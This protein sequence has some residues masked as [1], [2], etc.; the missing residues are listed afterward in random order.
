[1]NELRLLTLVSSIFS[2]SNEIIYLNIQA[3]SFSSIQYFD[4]LVPKNQEYFKKVFQIN[5]NKEMHI[6]VI[7]KSNTTKNESVPCDF[8]SIK[9][10]DEVVY[11]SDEK[12]MPA[13]LSSS[14]EK[15]QKGNFFRNYL[16]KNLN[17]K[18]R[19]SNRE[20]Y[21]PNK[22]DDNTKIKYKNMNFLNNKVS[23]TDTYMASSTYSNLQSLDWND[24]DHWIAPKTEMPNQNNSLNRAF[25]KLGITKL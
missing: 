7:Q 8:K 5:D 17:L 18:R 9:F 1:M 6:I 11:I 2:G 22:S 13:D 4:T 20:S 16:P 12:T 14:T 10:S 3:S 25:K 19:N 15:K 23:I 24:N 21:S